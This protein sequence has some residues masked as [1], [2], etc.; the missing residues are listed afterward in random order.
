MTPRLPMKLRPCGWGI[1]FG[2]EADAKGE[3]YV[4]ATL[5]TR[6]GQYNKRRGLFQKTK[7][8]KLA[9]YGGYDG[10]GRTWGDAWRVKITRQKDNTELK[11]I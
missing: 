1:S 8:G 11:L 5:E 6:S 4:I 2:R 10:T 7:V 3:T 9:G